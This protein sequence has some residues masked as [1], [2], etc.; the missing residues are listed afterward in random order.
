MKC[1]RGIQE[2]YIQVHISLLNYLHLFIFKC[3]ACV[4]HWRYTRN[5]DFKMF[6]LQ[7]L[8]SDAKIR[9]NHVNLYVFYRKLQILIDFLENS[10]RVIYWFQQDNLPVKFQHTDRDPHPPWSSRLSVARNIEGYIPVRRKKWKAHTWKNNWIWFRNWKARIS[11]G[12]QNLETMIKVEVVVG[13][14]L[15]NSY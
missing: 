10:F 6:F 11:A 9:R 3:I 8:N 4:S 2:S 5:E 7:S 14:R 13:I 15:M 12:L 1:E